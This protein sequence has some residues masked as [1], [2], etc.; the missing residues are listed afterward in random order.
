MSMNIITVKSVMKQSQWT[1]LYKDKTEYGKR[2]HRDEKDKKCYKRK[3][4]AENN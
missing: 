2:R 4:E 1:V 3:L